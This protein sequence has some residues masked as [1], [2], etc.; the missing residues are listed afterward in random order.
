MDEH[1]VHPDVAKVT[2]ATEAPSPIEVPQRLV[3]TKEQR[4]VLRRRLVPL[5]VSAFLGALAL[6]VP[7]EK[8]FMTTIGF[9]P[10]SVGV[11][12]A[13]YAVVVPFLEVPSGVLADRWSRR[14]V[15]ILA[16]I[17]AIVSVLVG[18]FSQSVGVYM[19]SAA[20]LGVF[21]ALQS[22]TFESVVYDT[23][24]EET[25]DSEAFERTIGRV[26][27]VE[28]IALVSSAL[29]G[30]A[31]AEIAPLR[32]TY[33]LTT[34]LLLASGG[35]LLA[36]REPQ[37][38]K[39]EEQEPLR[40]Q[41]GATYRM[42]FA[43]GNT[44]AI[45]ALTVLGALLMQGVLEFGPLWLVAL[46]VP[47]FLYG[48]QWAGLTSALGVGG[49]LGGHRWVTHPWGVRL[50]AATIVACCM[51]LALSHHALLVVAGQVVLTVLVVTVSIPVTRRLHDAV[52]S[53][54]RAGVASGVGTLT[55]L[56]FVPFA[57]VVGLVSE[58]AGVDRAGWVFV[59]VG[60]G[61]ALLILAVL[62]RSPL[63]VAAVSRAPAEIEPM[64]PA[65]RFL[66]PD[67][68]WPGHWAIPPADWGRLGPRVDDADVLEQVRAA[69]TEM[70]VILRQVIV[71][72]DIRGRTPDEVRAALSLDEEDQRIVLQQARG[73]V[74]ARVERY[75]E[76][77]GEDR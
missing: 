75:L 37:L 66:Q 11:M 31:I 48:P 52:P 26:R 43:P 58:R 55:W 2:P 49:V 38:H 33:F 32:A 59:V 1:D 41:I 77:V 13:V 40:R 70:P 30:G 18:G 23:V 51:V 19:I 57:I 12:A 17:A 36:F 72:R 62:P 29:I 63:P 61:A 10:A 44:R 3:L 22:G 14:G 34:P 4:A 5:Y 21:F 69:V 53:A 74:R 16:S 25:G 45:V 65:D 67:S 71:L 54:I 35:A 76:E 15:L 64:F 56:T 47:A 39:A 6:W 7:I 60:S 27:L 68:E 28:S 42:I 8:L 9:H 73:L 46:A 50:I 24:L 20:F